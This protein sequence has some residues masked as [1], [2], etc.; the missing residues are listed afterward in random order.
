MR[1]AY[2]ATYRD[3]FG[4]EA[5]TIENDGK[6][7]RMVVRGVGFTGEMLDDFEPSCDPSDPR[8]ASFTL[9]YGMLT[10]CLIECDIPIPVVF[11]EETLPGLLHVRLPLGDASAIGVAG[12]PDLFLTLT[13]VDQSFSSCGKHGWFENQLLEIQAALPDGMYMK[14]C[15]ACAFSDYFPAGNGIFGCL[16]CFRDNKAAYRAVKG[17]DGLFAIWDT[18]SGFVQETYLCPEFERRKPGSGYRG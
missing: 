8:M 7:L 15:F 3:R 17:K 9:I 1:A 6:T 4:E 10:D 2:P 18:L 13:V 14:C 16:A 5:T 11:G 12:P